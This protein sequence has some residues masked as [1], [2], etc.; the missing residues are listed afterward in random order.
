[1]HNL[2]GCLTVLRDGAAQCGDKSERT[3]G[4][5]CDH[6]KDAICWFMPTIPTAEGVEA[7]R[8]A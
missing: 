3:M 1:M 7:R 2:P 6:G 5:H 8:L 4:R